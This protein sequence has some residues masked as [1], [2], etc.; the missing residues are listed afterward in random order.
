MPVG[1]NG[2]VAGKGTY[3]SLTGS[4]WLVTAEGSCHDVAVYGL[5]EFALCPRR[6]V[7]SLEALRMMTMSRMAHMSYSL[8]S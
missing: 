6:S 1:L 3:G 8:N 2:S 7:G 5:M 4:C